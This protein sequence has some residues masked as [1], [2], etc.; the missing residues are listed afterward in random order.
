MLCTCHNLPALRHVGLRL[1]NHALIL[2]TL[3]DKLGSMKFLETLTEEELELTMYALRMDYAA[4]TDRE[5]KIKGLK[6]WIDFCQLGKCI[7]IL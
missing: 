2:K 4:F 1:K 5:A 6:R 3:C 7:S